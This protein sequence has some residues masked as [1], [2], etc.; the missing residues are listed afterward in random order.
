MGDAALPPDIVNEAERIT[1]LARR[2][3]DEAE[4]D[5]YRQRRETL[6]AE[7]GFNARVREEDA[8]AVLVCYP[9]EWVEGDTIRPD[10]IDDTDRAIERSLSGPGDPDDW[11]TLDAHNRAVAERVAERHDPVHGANAA[12]FADFMSNHYARRIESAS[13]AEIKEF[14]GEYFPR[15]AWPSDEQKRLVES[16]IP[17]ILDAAA[18]GAT[19]PDRRPS[20]R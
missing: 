2:A 13:P 18:D 20:D 15:N 19:Q 3:A 12:A 1:R 11:D 14:L 5:A 16:S 6:L 8:R 17:L 7:Q 9:A 10:R 4:R